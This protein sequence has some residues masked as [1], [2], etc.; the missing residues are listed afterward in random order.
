MVFNNE[1]PAPQWDPC[2]SQPFPSDLT[3]PPDIGGEAK[4]R[5]QAGGTA[6]AEGEADSPLS[7]ELDMVL[8]PRTLAS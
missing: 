6:E 1:I 2:P 8:N 4:E 3:S 5:A 7:R